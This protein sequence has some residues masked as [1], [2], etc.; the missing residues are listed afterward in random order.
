MNVT[1]KIVSGLVVK[2]LTSILSKGEE[3]A[4][5]IVCFDWV[6]PNV[7]SCELIC[8]EV[9]SAEL[10]CIEFVSS[11]L[12]SFDSIMLFLASNSSFIFETTL[13]IPNL[14]SSF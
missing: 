3:D 10:F 8:I 14:T 12:N 2:T 13:L 4:E 11:E 1:P 6:S 9:V 7:V 5:E